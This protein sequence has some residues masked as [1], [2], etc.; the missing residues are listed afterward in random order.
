MV[1]LLLGAF[2]VA[3]GL[4]T[5]AVWATPAKAGEPFRATHSWILGDVR[6]LAVA[7]ALV[8]AIGFVLAG[9]GFLSHQSWWGAF[10]IGAGVV[11]LLLMGLYFN[12]WLLAGIAISGGVLYAGVQALQQ[13]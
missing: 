11:A 1:R 3:H 4:V 2:V 8:A 7:L 6:S 10:G 12:P 13:A 9:V 5:A